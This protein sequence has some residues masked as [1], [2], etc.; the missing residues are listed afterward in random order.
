MGGAVK[1][2]TKKDSPA[3]TERLSPAMMPP[4]AL[5]AKVTPAECATMAPLSTRMGSPPARKQRA[6]VDDG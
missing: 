3:S 5:A 4:S 1:V 2:E 6:M